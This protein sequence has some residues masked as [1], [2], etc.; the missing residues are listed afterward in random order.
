[1]ESAS[2]FPAAA[3]IAKDANINRLSR[4]NTLRMRRMNWSTWRLMQLLY[5]TGNTLIT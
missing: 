3:T 5:P 1:M 4:I 2:P